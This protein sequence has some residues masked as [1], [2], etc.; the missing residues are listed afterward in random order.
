MMMIVD[1]VINAV[2][3]K[4]KK[5]MKDNNDYPKLCVYIE[6]DF[7]DRCLREIKAAQYNALVVEFHEK[8]TIWGY[9]IY[10]IR[11]KKHPKFKVVNLS[12]D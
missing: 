12:S 10:V 2:I 11:D 3:T 6:N 8:N 4:V 1:E 9:P 7:M 5:H